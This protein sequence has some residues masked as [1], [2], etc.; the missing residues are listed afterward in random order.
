M[1]SKEKYEKIILEKG[2]SL[3]DEDL[4]FKTIMDRIR[5]SNF[6]SKYL[7]KKEIV[8]Y[9]KFPLNRIVQINR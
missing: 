8:P 3:I 4:N 2:Q 7:D 5:K 1:D 9:D 6:E